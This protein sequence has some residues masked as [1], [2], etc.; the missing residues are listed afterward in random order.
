MKAVFAAWLLLTAGPAVA[1]PSAHQADPAR[2]RGVALGVATTP[3]PRS[4]CFT[5][6]SLD[7]A[8]DSA[9]AFPRLSG[10]S[11]W[12]L[13]KQLKDYASG[14]R[15][16][17]V[18]SP[19][20]ALLT[21]AE[22]QDVAAY[23]ASQQA[24]PRRSVEHDPEALQIGASI[25]AAGLVDK[26]VQACVNCHG[27]QGRGLPPSFPYL[28]GQYAPYFELQMQLWKRGERNNDPL[29]VMKHIADQLSDDQI[30]AL[31]L[32]FESLSAASPSQARGAALPPQQ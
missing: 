23:Y 7:G 28:A 32:Y 24:P 27:P 25:A 3:S 13:Y 10:Q 4:A 12:Y 6:H 9:G 14:A 26:Q 29:G 17:P 18:M 1:Q 30:R 8:G 31:A 22:M 21:D 16:N 2:G 19:I 20:A 11:A 5:C 15:A